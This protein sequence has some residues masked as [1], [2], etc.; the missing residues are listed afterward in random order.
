MGDI[1]YPIRSVNILKA[2]GRSIMDSQL[3]HGFALNCSRASQAMPQY[4]K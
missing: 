1:K 4:I 2:H 3:I